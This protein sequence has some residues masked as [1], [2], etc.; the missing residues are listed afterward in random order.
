[1]GF[2]RLKRPITISEHLNAAIVVHQQRKVRECLPASLR[3]FR[4]FEQLLRLLGQ[5][6]GRALHTFAYRPAWQTVEPEFVDQKC[7]SPLAGKRAGQV[8]N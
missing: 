8:T 7:K 6:V 3:G 2:Q 1:M 5:H 4:G